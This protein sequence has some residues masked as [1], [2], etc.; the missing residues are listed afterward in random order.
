MSWKPEVKIGSDPKWCANAL[1]FATKEEAE[2]SAKDLMYRWMAVT[3]YR[4]A[5][6]DHPVNYTYVDG[7]ATRIKEHG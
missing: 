7:A 3:D 6:S 4:A 1:V 2:A 5:E